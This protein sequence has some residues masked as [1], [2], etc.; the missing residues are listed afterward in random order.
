[1]QQS[2][3]AVYSIQQ[4]AGIC[5]SVYNFLGSLSAVGSP[6]PTNVFNELCVSIKIKHLAFATKCI[7]SQPQLPAQNYLVAIPSHRCFWRKYPVLYAIDQQKRLCQ[8]VY[9]YNN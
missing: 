9:T 8:R 5:Q 2:N 1:M 6:P 7:H 4:E 3:A